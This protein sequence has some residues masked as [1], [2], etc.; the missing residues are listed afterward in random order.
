ML[1]L[2]YQPGHYPLLVNNINNKSELSHQPKITTTQKRTRLSRKPFQYH[3]RTYKRKNSS[4]NEP[5]TV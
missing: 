1:K 2:S 4:R 5:A 3:M